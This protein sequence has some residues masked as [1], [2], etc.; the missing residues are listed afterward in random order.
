MHGIYGR[1]FSPAGIP[2]DAAMPL[3]PSFT[4]GYTDLAMRPSGSFVLV[5]EDLPGVGLAAR[6]FASDGSAPQPAFRV[7]ESVT[8]SQLV[9]R[10]AIDDEGRFVVVWQSGNIFGREFRALRP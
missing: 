8:G 4:T 10:V 2:L 5:W 1:R 6:V 3:V 9:P 7:S